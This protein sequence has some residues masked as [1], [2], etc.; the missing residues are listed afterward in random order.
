MREIWSNT[1]LHVQYTYS[2]LLSRNKE[3]SK[4][5]GM[6]VNYDSVQHIK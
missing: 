3:C 6:V 5:G 2:Y 1:T 4:S